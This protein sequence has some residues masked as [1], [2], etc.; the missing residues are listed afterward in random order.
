[1]VRSIFTTVVAENEY[2]T[3]QLRLLLSFSLQRHILSVYEQ[4]SLCDRCGERD[5]RNAL[6]CHVD[7]PVLETR[8][9]CFW[10]GGSE[11]F[12]Q[13]TRTKIRAGIGRNTTNLGCDIGRDF[14]SMPEVVPTNG[15]FGTEE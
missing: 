2:Y 4:G 8:C 9:D 13:T 14:R 10:F 1:M 15:V 3:R 11:S 5:G 12:L 6:V 7:D